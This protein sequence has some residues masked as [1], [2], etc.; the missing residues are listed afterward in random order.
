MF[1]AGAPSGS[2]GCP[3]R[4]VCA[5]APPRGLAYPA[6][7]PISALP[8]SSHAAW[9]IM[10][11]PPSER[12]RL[13]LDGRGRRSEQGGRRTEVGKARLGFLIADAGV[14]RKHR[15]DD[16]LV[17]KRRER[18]RIERFAREGG[19]GGVDA[20]DV[21]VRFDA[22]HVVGG[23]DVAAAGEPAAGFDDEVTQPARGGIDQD[24]FE[25][26]EFLVVHRAQL[27]TPEVLDVVGFQVAERLS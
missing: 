6:A 24:P 19:G 3:P 22:R 21:L 20:E 17:R 9:R 12:A 5:A 26:A 13:S 2:A 8:S 7:Y 14:A 16:V 11:G 1:G 15:G 27:E 4:P 25:H 10:Q 23:K 18:A